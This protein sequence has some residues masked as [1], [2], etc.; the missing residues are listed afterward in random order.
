M[1]WLQALTAG[2]IQG[3]TEFLPVSSSGHLVIFHT[4]FGENDESYLAFTVFLHLATL[5]SVFIVFYKDVRMLISEFLALIADIVKG[6]PNSKSP[7]RRFLWMVIIGTIPAGLI[8]VLIKLLGLSSNL[9]NVFLVAVMLIVTSVLM[10]L[11]DRLKEGSYT[12]A[13]APFKT[14]LIVGVMQGIA[15]IPGL[16]RSG[17]TIFGGRFGGLTK[18]FAVRFSFMLSI[19]AILGAGLVEMIDVLKMG[20]IDFAFFSWAIG[21]I[22]ATLCGVL[23]IKLI[24][25]L[26][27][28]N[29]FYVFGIYCLL[30]SFFAFLTGFG[31]IN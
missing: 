17:S 9:E 22:A 6:R 24:K 5:L 11:V 21:F 29:R 10:F 12:E 16:S 7:Q 4:L 30:A 2:A 18:E 3:V 20:H 1:D 15:I 8:G 26:I 25:L 14:T 23:A 13:D 31:I 27:I 28:S 19:P